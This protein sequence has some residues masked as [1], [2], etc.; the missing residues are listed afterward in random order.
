MLPQYD[1]LPA[2]VPVG[3]FLIRMQRLVVTLSHMAAYPNGCMLEVQI[4]GT[5]GGD[6]P[7]MHSSDAFDHLVFGV[8]E[9]HRRRRRAG[10]T[11][12]A[13]T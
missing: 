13:V 2:I 11:V 12:L 4:S 1:V 5:A 10:P 6:G 9:D 3:R 7:P 8:R